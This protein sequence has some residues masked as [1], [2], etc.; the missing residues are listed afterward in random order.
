MAYIDKYGVRYSDDKRILE[1]CPSDFRG[2][3]VIEKG[4][5]IIDSCAFENCIGLS[6]II[7]PDSL[8]D[9]GELAFH[10]CAGLR[11]LSIP[12]SISYIEGGAFEGCYGL[13]LV[14]F[15][16]KVE[17]IGEGIFEDCWDLTQICVPKGAK[18]LYQ[19][20]FDDAKVLEGCSHA[21]IYD[22]RQS[23]ISEFVSKSKECKFTL[24][25]GCVPFTMPPAGVELPI[26]IYNAFILYGVKIPDNLWSYS[27][28]RMHNHIR[29]FYYEKIGTLTPRKGCYYIVDCTN[30][31]KTLAYYTYN[32]DLHSDD[33]YSVPIS[34]I[35]SLEL[36][37]VN[38]KPLFNFVS[39]SVD[40]K[41]K[42][43]NGEFICV[44]DVSVVENEYKGKV[45]N[46][47]KVK[48][49]IDE[50]R[51]DE[52]YRDSGY[53]REE[54]EEASWYALTGGQRGDY[55][56]EFGADDMY[57]KLGF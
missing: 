12:A 42:I 52:M 21:R 34:E 11:L 6:T 53:T 33:L 8:K 25:A 55:P 45:Y 9:I 22:D 3:Y 29:M 41:R 38:L 7:F 1:R 44:E 51:C 13:S 35:F 54:A 36:V 39:E 24:P 26:D 28:R 47:Y 37:C 2:D 49:Y 56:G 16:G 5:E 10:Q 30:Q 43:E 17:Y 46:S 20:K 4:T 40:K 23:I 27:G 50:P 48:W 15:D 31:E 18:D 14:K 32:L 57:D 19:L